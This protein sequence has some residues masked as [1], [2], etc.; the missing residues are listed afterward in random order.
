M[1]G[2]LDVGRV[3][4]RQSAA[5]AIKRCAYIRNSKMLHKLVQ[6]LLAFFQRNQKQRLDG[7]E[8][9]GC[10]N[11]ASHG[12]TALESSKPCNFGGKFRLQG[13]AGNKSAGASATT[14]CPQEQQQRTCNKVSKRV[15]N[16]TTNPERLV[17]WGPG[18][19]ELEVETEPCICSFLTL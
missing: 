10:N 4:E 11:L 8:S 6:P 18:V 14:A 15:E 17:G 13:S 16:V 12:D 5:I 7:F 9:N 2:S 19:V 3:C 1:S